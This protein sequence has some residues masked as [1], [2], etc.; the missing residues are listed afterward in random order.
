MTA[1]RG[2]GRTL[3]REPNFFVKTLQRT[4][5]VK[6][7]EIHV[8]FLS[9][10]YFFFVLSAYYII[11]P[12]RDEMGVAGG[13]RNLSWL[14]TGTLVAMLVVHPPFAALVARLPRKRF[15]PITYRFFM[16]NL[17]IFFFLLKLLPEDQNIWVGRAFFVWTS[18]FNLFVVSVFWAFMA[19]VYRNEQG[20]RL[21]AFIGVG[22]T[23]GAIVGAGTTAVLAERVGPVHLLLVSILLLEIA[24]QCVGRLSRFFSGSGASIRGEG[25]PSIGGLPEQP[26]GAGFG[27]QRA[28]IAEVPI[29]GGVLAGISSAIRSPYLLGIV[30]Y[31]LLFT[32]ASTFVYF[33][34]AHLVEQAL[35]GR[36]V[37]TAFFAKIDVAVNTLTLLTQVFLTARI[38]KAVGVAVTLTVLPAI[39]V[40]GFLGLGFMPILAVLV[41][42]QVLRR[43]GNHAVAR[44]TREILYTVVRREDKYKAKNFI[45]TFIYRGGD[46]VGAWSYSLMLWL[47]LSLSAIAFVAVPIAGT[48]LLVGLWLGR[49]QETL[50]RAQLML[51]ELAAAPA[52]AAS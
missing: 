41:A 36:A 47:G 46:Q 28:E 3:G 19:D 16:A 1:A 52:P 23:L 25:G 20:K 6:E 49:T 34:Q 21:F 51:D 15:I 48:F 18:V 2:H 11:R 22:G 33:Q 38:I 39:C 32:I 40:L 42:F 30:A 44:P 31:M 50:A 7:E 24:V 4:V 17:L 27:R 13:V 5:P 29:G 45:D 14:F 9:C 35:E 43:A 26:A 37:R 8:L 10:A 12:L